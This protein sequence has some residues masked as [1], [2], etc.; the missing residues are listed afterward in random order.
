[1]EA[2][3]ETLS[4]IYEIVKSDPEPTTYLC[5]PHEIILK[6]T[7]EWVS[8]QKQLEVLASEKLIV[9]KQLDKIAISITSSDI[10]K[11]KAIKNNF[12]NNNFILPIAVKNPTSETKK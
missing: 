5:T 10:A 12:V 1:M 8:I 9:I 11:A 3:Y 2:H 7:I 6:H 4:T